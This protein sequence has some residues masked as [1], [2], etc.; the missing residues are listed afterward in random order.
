MSTMSCTIGN[1][2]THIRTNTSIANEMRAHTKTLSNKR[3]S[4][5]Y[6]HRKACVVKGEGKQEIPHFV[7]MLHIVFLL[8]REL[9]GGGGGGHV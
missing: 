4:T 1:T 3:A 2:S 9:G 5:S 6:L 8:A 7:H